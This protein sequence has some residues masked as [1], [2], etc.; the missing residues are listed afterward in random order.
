MRERFAQTARAIEE[1]DEIHLLIMYDG[2]DW[3]PD[4]V[5][6]PGVSNPTESRAIRN[7][8]EWGEKLKELRK[9]E[10]ELTEFI[11]ISL[12]LIRRVRDSLGAKYADVL[13]QHYIDG[14]PYSRIADASGNAVKPSTAKQRVSVACDWIDSVGVSR[15]LR[16]EVDV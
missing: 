4:G 10:T 2:E 9:R 6:I 7:V 11:S 8:D 14:E 5:R 3:K 15:L 16:G 13:E 1:L 12:V